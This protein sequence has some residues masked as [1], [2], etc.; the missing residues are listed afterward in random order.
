MREPPDGV[1]SIED[2]C[3]ESERPSEPIPN[4][5]FDQGPLAHRTPP[6]PDSILGQSGSLTN[7]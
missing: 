3:R 7:G 6:S 2:Q 5:L 4:F 1:D